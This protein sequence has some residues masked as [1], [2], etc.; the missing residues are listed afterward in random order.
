MLLLF[1][2][3]NEARKNPVLAR[4]KLGDVEIQP[5]LDSAVGQMVSSMLQPESKKEL[6]RCHLRR[7][8]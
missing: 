5:P 6:D 8:R 4:L 2:F 3:Q 7:Q 1:G